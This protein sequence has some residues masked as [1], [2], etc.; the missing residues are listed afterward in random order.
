MIAAN[1][2]RDTIDGMVGAGKTARAPAPELSEGK[3]SPMLCGAKG[4]GKEKG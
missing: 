1:K 3:C 2:T 4:K